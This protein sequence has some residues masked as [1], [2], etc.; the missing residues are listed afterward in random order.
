MYASHNP[1]AVNERDVNSDDRRRSS[2]RNLALL[3]VAA[4]FTLIAALPH[5]L[6][7]AAS[8]ARA[9]VP[10]GSHAAGVYSIDG[11]FGLRES[12]YQELLAR[13]LGN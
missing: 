13:L 9:G 5:P 11:G 12:A 1:K 2:R 4:A 6:L 3:V 8:N 10:D 7:Q